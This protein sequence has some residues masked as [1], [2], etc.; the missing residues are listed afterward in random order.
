M[1]QQLAC[2]LVIFGYE[3]E[4][5][6]HERVARRI[7]TENLDAIIWDLNP[8]ADA[9]FRGL[10][11]LRAQRYYPPVLAL[12]SNPEPAHAVMALKYGC[13]NVLCHPT[14]S[15]LQ[16]T[17]VLYLEAAVEAAIRR[18]RIEENIAGRRD[19]G[20]RVG[21]LEIDPRRCVVRTRSRTAELTNR[22]L[23]LI[24][25]L[26]ETPGVARTKQEL[27]ENVWGSNEESLLTSLT[28]HI[29]R[30]RMKIEPDL[31]NPQYIVGVW[32]VGYKLISPE[33][34]GATQ[35]SSERS[36]TSKPK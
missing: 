22:E 25:Q 20:V 15:T 30:L 28:T 19:F 6:V 16:D 35:V 29:N 31:K 18:R 36:W 12:S 10:A 23:N 7:A 14:V 11:E 21:D 1:A 17:W 34:E 8:P 27:L 26:A 24:L 3:V 2:E 5:E 33:W 32:G 9:A 13:D 4:M